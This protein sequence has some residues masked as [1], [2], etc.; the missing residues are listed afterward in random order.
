M[1]SHHCNI[2]SCNT[3]TDNNMKELWNDPEFFAWNLQRE[4]LWINELEAMSD[5]Q[6]QLMC[7]TLPETFQF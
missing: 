5:E 3:C 2:E 7:Q 6:W 4:S 1:L